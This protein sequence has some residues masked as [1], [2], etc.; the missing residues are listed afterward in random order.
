MIQTNSELQNP[1]KMFF[2][3]MVKKLAEMFLFENS[4]L[5]LFLFLQTVTKSQTINV[6]DYPLL[7][8]IPVEILESIHKRIIDFFGSKN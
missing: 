7:R 6:D 2:T 5:D 3:A 1:N 4:N 8:S